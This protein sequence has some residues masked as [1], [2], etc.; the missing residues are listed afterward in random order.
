MPRLQ[1]GP[2]AHTAGPVRLHLQGARGESEG[3]HREEAVKGELKGIDGR[4]YAYT[5]ILGYDL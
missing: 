3:D 4:L 2:A 1:C 5:C